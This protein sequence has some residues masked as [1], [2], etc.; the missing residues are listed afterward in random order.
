MNHN[1]PHVLDMPQVLDDILERDFV[2]RPKKDACSVQ[3]LI[4]NIEV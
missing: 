3:S 4:D 1:G 2:I